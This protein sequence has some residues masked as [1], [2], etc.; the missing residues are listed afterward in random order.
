[1]NGAAVP[2]PRSP[3]SG[4]W[5]VVL[6]LVDAAPRGPWPRAARRGPDVVEELTDVVRET[7]ADGRAGF[8]TARRGFDLQHNL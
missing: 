6:D 7:V 8:A 3:R 1:M 4:D 2:P 5:D